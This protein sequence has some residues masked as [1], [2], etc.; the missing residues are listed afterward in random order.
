MGV[1]VDHGRLSRYLRAA[2]AAPRTSRGQ[3]IVEFALV[4]P[5]FLLMLVAVVDF[6]R[7]L[8][9]GIAL[10]DAAFQGA[11]VGANATATAASIRTTVR[12]DLPS[13]V[14]VP[15]ADITIN[16]ANRSA[17]STVTVT[18]RWT[19]PPIMPATRVFAPSGIVML[20]AGSTAVQ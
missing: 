3:G 12:A 7:A 9:Y 2:L 11:R 18:V 5:I 19:F 15:D 13:E 20:G 14:I 8:R 16:P 1:L 4:A 6:G 17:G 10:N